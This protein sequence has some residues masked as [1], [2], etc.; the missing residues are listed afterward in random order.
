MCFRWE[1]LGR[2]S[3][4]V[5]HQLFASLYHV[6]ESTSKGRGT[7]C[8]QVCTSTCQ[9]QWKSLLV[10]ILFFKNSRWNPQVIW[11]DRCTLK[12]SFL[13]LPFFSFY[14]EE[15]ILASWQGLVIDVSIEFFMRYFL[16]KGKKSVLYLCEDERISCCLAREKL[17]DQRGITG[18]VCYI[19]LSRLLLHLRSFNCLTHKLDFSNHQRAF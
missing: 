7:V 1:T 2:E 5:P 19:W 14:G 18:N 12:W 4:P 11:R 6:F 3:R 16:K 10:S 9:F 17:K 15:I 8:F 13:F